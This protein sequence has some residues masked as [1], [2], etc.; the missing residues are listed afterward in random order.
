MDRSTTE[1]QG[2]GD[3]WKEEPHY[4]IESRPRA[5]DG[6]TQTNNCT[7]KPHPKPKR[8]R[9]PQPTQQPA[10]STSSSSAAAAFLLRRRRRRPDSLPPCAN[11]RPPKQAPLPPRRA[12][13]LGRH[14]RVSSS[15]VSVS[16][17]SI[18]IS[19]SSRGRRSPPR[20]PPRSNAPRAR[21]LQQ[22]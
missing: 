6:P 7:H 13:R 2:K 10:T 17:I 12:A 14:A 19:S 21:K 4:N 9:P 11:P 3:G 5:R 1:R 15:V 20:L 8:E 16:G 22:R 18:S